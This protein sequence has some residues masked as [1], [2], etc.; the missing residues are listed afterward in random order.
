MLN[1]N[2]KIDD[3]LKTLSF[4]IALIIHDCVYQ[5][6][7]I[8]YHS[9]NDFSTFRFLVSGRTSGLKFALKF[10]KSLGRFKPPTLQMTVSQF[11]TPVID[12]ILGEL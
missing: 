1:L 3:L 9:R 6:I 7:R 8:F 5:F 2:P 11:A 12:V 10:G 4:V